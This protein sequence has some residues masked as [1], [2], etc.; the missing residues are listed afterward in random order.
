MTISSICAT[1]DTIAVVGREGNTL[2][3]LRNNNF[4]IKLFYWN[5]EDK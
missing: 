3:E 4:Y 5:Y 1:N 2:S